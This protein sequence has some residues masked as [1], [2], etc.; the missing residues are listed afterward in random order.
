MGSTGE[1]ESSRLISG[2]AHV[3]LIIQSG[4]LPAAKEF[5]GHTLGLIS[6]PVPKAMEGR[7][8]WFDITPGGQQIHIAVGPAEVE[9]ARHPCF[10][11]DSEE[12]LFQLQQRIYE[13]FTSTDREGKPKHAD[14]PGEK[15][16]G[17]T[18]A[19]F[20]TRFFARDFAGNRLEFSL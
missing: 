8:A 6:V 14:K 13:H 7:L 1:I 16:S 11:I 20:P 17:S 10:K 2:I 19:E 9:S 5:Y 3:N 18:G 15:I 12:A 4:D